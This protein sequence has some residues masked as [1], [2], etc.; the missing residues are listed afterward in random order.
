[1]DRGVFTPKER[2]LLKTISNKISSFIVQKL[3]RQTIENLKQQQSIANGN[4]D[5]SIRKWLE[6]KNL[7]TEEIDK[8]LKVKLQF[9]K[10]ETLCK[11]GT[12]ASYIIIL[13]KGLAK[14]FVE[15]NTEK[16]F[17]FKFIKAFDFIGLSTIYNNN[18]YSFSA[19]ALT[20]CETY[21]IDIPTFKN[22]IDKNKAFA[23]EISVW[24][25]QTIVSH[26]NRM[27]TIANKQSMGRLAESLLYLSEKIFD[28]GSIKN[29][30]SRKEIA[31]YAAMSTE[32]AVRFMSDFK[33]DGV[34]EIN[35][36]EII[37]KKWDVLKLISRS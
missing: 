1:M 33:K 30:I 28:G 7:S 13:N 29:T 36:K 19:A 2:Q 22:I 17:N 12:F 20:N 5:T 34:I 32:N 8:L 26:L 21:L 14:N 10:G 16:A 23:N 24:Y 15:G 4:N 3:L 6:N 27:S 31:A 35:S 18:T 25:C 11:Q 37:I 9:S